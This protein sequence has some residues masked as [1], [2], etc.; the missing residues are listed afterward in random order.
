MN[1]YIYTIIKA[2]NNNENSE[3]YSENKSS[4]ENSIDNKFEYLYENEILPDY[5]KISSIRSRFDTSK[6]KLK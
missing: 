3:N 6:N 5:N 2:K 4:I 1:N